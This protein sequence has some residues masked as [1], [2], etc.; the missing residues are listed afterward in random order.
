MDAMFW[1]LEQRKK[2]IARYR[3]EMKAEARAEMLAE[4]QAKARLREEGEPVDAWLERMGRELED[5][6]KN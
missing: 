6:R 4:L 1:A 3:A 5:S 2:R